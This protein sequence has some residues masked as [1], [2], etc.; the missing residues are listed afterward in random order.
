M[1]EDMKPIPLKMS[2]LANQFNDCRTI[3]TALG[4]DNRQLIVIALLQNCGGMRVGQLTKYTHL[5]RPAVSHHLKVLKDAGIISMFKRGTMNFY[6]VNENNTLW[7]NLSTLVEHINELIDD[8]ATNRA[9][10]YCFPSDD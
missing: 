8:I 10:G 9:D 1:K 2:L 6:H 5:S 7:N 4:D 3:F